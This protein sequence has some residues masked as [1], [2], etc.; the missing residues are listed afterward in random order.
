[1]FRAI[2]QLKIQADVSRIEAIDFQ[3]IRRT[4]FGLLNARAGEALDDAFDGRANPPRSGA[5]A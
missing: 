4:G 1:M 2:F 3:P 5:A